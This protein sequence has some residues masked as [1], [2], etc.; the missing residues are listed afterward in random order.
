MVH[1]GWHKKL[2][3]FSDIIAFINRLQKPC[4]FQKCQHKIKRH[5]TKASHDFRYPRFWK[6][7]KN[8][9]IYH[10]SLPIYINLCTVV[11]VP[12]DNLSVLYSQRRHSGVKSSKRNNSVKTETSLLT[13]KWNWFIHM[14]KLPL[15]CTW[16]STWQQYNQD[17]RARHQRLYIS[18]L[19]TKCS[20]LPLH[21]ENI[22][23]TII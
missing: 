22:N 12:A 15:L 18:T 21:T 23:W 17:F 2:Q 16:S 10:T 8:G 19:K 14:N 13:I 5:F 4:R 20:S 6:L 11:Q 1:H 3:W 9:D 7:L